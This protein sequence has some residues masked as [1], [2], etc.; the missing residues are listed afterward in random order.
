MASGARTRL[1]AVLFVDQV[2]STTTLQQLGDLEADE[3]RRR[4]E[5]VLDES[6]D[7]AG[8]T[9]VKKTGDGR[10]AV[11]ESASDAIN[12]AVRMQE[13]C[14]RDNR[15]NRSKPPLCI[16]VGVSVGDV[17]EEDADF[18]GT[19]VVEAARLESAAPEPGILCTD[20]AR[21]LAGS[22]SDGVFET[23]VDVDAKGFRDPIA[24][25]VVTWDREPRRPVS[26]IPGALGAGGR[27][28]FAGRESELADARKAW[29]ATIDG[30]VTGILIAG[31]PGVGKTR[32]ARELAIEAIDDGALVLFGRCDEGVG[33]PFQPIADALAHYVDLVRPMPSDLGRFPGELRRLVPHLDEDVEGLPDMI[34]ADS[35]TE[36]Y[37][38]FD[39][40]LSWLET[41]AADQPLL[42]VIDDIHW[43]SQ[44]TMDLL[45][46]LLRRVPGAPLC[47]VGT[48]RDTATDESLQLLRFLGDMQRAHATVSINLTGLDASGIRSF[49]RSAELDVSSGDQALNDLVERLLGQTAGNAF[50]LG[51]MVSMLRER[52]LDEIA[53]AAPAALGQVVL[54]RVSRLSLSAVELLN[55]AAVA[56]TEV[57]LDV[58]ALATRRPRGELVEAAD[59]ALRAGLLVEVP[60]VP[61]RYRF[62]HDLVRSTVYETMSLGRRSQRHHEMAHAIEEVHAK[63]L[64]EY[65]DDLAYH[66]VRSADPADVDRAVIVAQ[67]AG[68]QASE[69]VGFATAVVHYENALGLMDRPGCTHPERLRGRL[70]LSLGIAMKRAG[71]KGVRAMLFDAAEIASAEDDPDTVVHAALANTRGFFSSAGRTDEGRVRLLEMALDAVDPDDSAHTAKLLANLSVEL[72]FGS[73]HERRQSLS[74]ESLAMAERMDDPRCLAHVIN[75]RINFLWNASGLSERLILCDRLQTITQDFD[76]PQWHYSAASSQFQAAMEAGDLDLTDRCL[77]RMKS[78]AEELRQPVVQS[79]LRMREAVRAIVGGDLGLGE[80]LATECYEIGQEAG[81]PD[82]LTFYFGQ[83]I[84]LRF[85]QGRLGEL[86]AIVADEAAANP[87]LPSMQA[88]LALIYCEIGEPDRAREQ[89]EELTDRHHELLH[90]LSW[91]VMTSLLADVC[92]QLDDA[93]RAEK[94]HRALSPYRAQ[95]I[96]N[97][98]NW[99]GSV[100]HYLAMLEH[101]MGRF[102][103][104]DASFRAAVEWHARM[105]APLL[106]ARTEIDWAVSLLR[107]PVP[108]RDHASQLIAS[109]RSAASELGLGRVL[110][111]AT[112]LSQLL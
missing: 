71:I 77:E 98:T 94:L 99:F 53:T 90:D 103:D 13:R 55:A 106:L 56:S 73:D 30:E 14:D 84:N 112:E 75:Q 51:E 10:M 107:R 21:S 65:L 96:D 36:Q 89:F 17:T 110:A 15:L 38:L 57:S 6:I 63:D 102:D 48:Y 50:F 9:T 16:R 23:R 22:R 8:G 37:R 7:H 81:Q 44:P 4:L 105:P 1:L 54:D 83:L 108:E 5:I 104:A 43:A 72:T 86:V 29:S 78:A 59:E 67:L 20:L 101:V 34:R 69:Q 100:G 33:A 31:E 3:L 68:D 19:T 85:H 64:T 92:F 80:T 32:L 79:Y 42:L 28:D 2:A 87:G 91:L 95:C 74:D 35:E 60:G 12:C 45:R 26:S 97:G 27:F 61:V 109:S 76:A 40:V 70:E 93:Q 41:A 49:L 47:I 58:L 24:A 111:R 11:F 82:A 39:A 66:Y 62:Q 18:H 52:G 88:A 46:H 25:W